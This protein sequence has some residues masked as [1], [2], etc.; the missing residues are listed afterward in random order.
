MVTKSHEP[1][2]RDLHYR[3]HR[4]AGPAKSR[5]VPTCDSGLTGSGSSG[6]G[7]RTLSP[8][9]QNVRDLGFQ[10]LGVKTLNFCERGRAMTAGNKAPTNRVVREFARQYHCRASDLGLAL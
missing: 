3:R 2:S 5:T 10:A 4:H 7:S 1:P 6:V 8:K 9:P